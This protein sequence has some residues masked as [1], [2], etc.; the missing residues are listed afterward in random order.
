M[1][2]SSNKIY[3]NR[4]RG[5]STIIGGIIFLVL[6]TAGFSSFFVAMD[7]QSDTINAQRTISNSII[8]KTQEQFSI[9]VA[10]DDSNSYQLG[11]QVKN[12]GPNPVQI[13]NIWIIN[14]TEA[15]YPVKNI[16]IN[17]KDAFI[18]PG[19]NSSILA[20]QL[21]YMLPNDY[22]IKVI[23]TLGTIE[24][25]ELKVGGNNYLLAEM[26]TIPPDVR[27]GENASL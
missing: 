11:I 17:Y 16:P 8:E 14:K 12:E 19:T 18:T 4:K 23:S 10:T 24:K 13:S 15:N 3:Q 9:A 27:Q 5:I 20:S 21:L 25:F 2:N 1:V 6:L 26:F 22:D 7:V